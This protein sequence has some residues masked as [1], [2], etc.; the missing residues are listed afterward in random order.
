VGNNS[1]SPI[2]LG[3]VSLR[4]LIHGINFFPEL[5]GIGKYSGEMA[6]WLAA[7]GHDVRVVT[8]PPYY[9]QW[10]IA[11]GY[12]NR[13]CRE[14]VN[15][16]PA[17]LWKKGGKYRGLSLPVVGTGQAFRIE[18]CAAFGEFCAVQ[19]PDHVAANLLATGCGDG[20][21]ATFDECACDAVGG[22]FKWCANVAACAGFKG[23][24]GFGF[25]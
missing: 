14:E 10:R 25:G 1:C 23:G 11:V 18:T 8:A 16:P 3:S 7:Q 15:P 12:A 6:Q 21:R 20:N 4:I 17:P 24:C 2:I 22:A 13:W 9:P 5:T 19:F